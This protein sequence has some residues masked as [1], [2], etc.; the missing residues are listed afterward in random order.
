VTPTDVVQFVEENTTPNSKW[1]HETEIVWIF[2]WYQ[3]AE[4]R[5]IQRAL[6]DAVARDGLEVRGKR[7]TT[8]ELAT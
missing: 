1:I 2:S 6:E 8:P 7:Y 4:T 5:H 3:D